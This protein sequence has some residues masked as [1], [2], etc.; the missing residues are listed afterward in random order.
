MNAYTEDINNKSKQ[1]VE[2]FKADKCYEVFLN[3]FKLLFYIG[4]EYNSDNGKRPLKSIDSS[5]DV[6]KFDVS[7]KDEERSVLRA[8][9][10]RRF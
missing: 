2:Y 1:P 7:L 9:Y 10:L 6:Y 4:H 8:E 3:C 5:Y